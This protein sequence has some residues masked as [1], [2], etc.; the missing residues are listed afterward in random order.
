MIAVDTSALIAIAQAERQSDVCLSALARTDEAIIS[1]G[2]LTEA[3]VVAGRRGIAAETASLLE[4]YPFNVIAVT[5]STAHRVA[6]A[7]SRWGRGLHPAGLNLGDCFAYVVAK[8]HSCPLLFV[9]KDFAQTDIES[10]L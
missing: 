10:V 8:E 2:T 4:K 6:E 1:V 3:L 5:A 7:Y 9:G